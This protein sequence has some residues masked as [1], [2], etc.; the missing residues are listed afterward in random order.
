ML[1]FVALA[2]F[3]GLMLFAAL[4]DI[5]TMTI[6]NRVSLILI[7]GF[8]IMALWTGMAP[9]AIGWH[10]AASAF[11]L[12]VCFVL[13]NFGWVG[14]GDAKLAASTALWFGFA[15]LAEYGVVTAILGGVLT[16]LI[17]GLRQAALP[18]FLRGS[19]WLV[20]LHDPASGIPYG[21]ALAGAG[22]VVYPHTAVWLAA[23]AQ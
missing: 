3:P 2:L 22:L 13:F 11:V 9:S 5:F 10:V 15:P 20:R 21:V 16:L 19:G 7:G 14:G 17:I 12:A 1:D 18:E 6:P 23:V 4:S 8:F